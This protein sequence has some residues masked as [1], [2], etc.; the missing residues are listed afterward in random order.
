MVI[1]YFKN[2]L[3]LRNYKFH[4]GWPYYCV[5]GGLSFV[6][7]CSRLFMSVNWMSI[8]VPFKILAMR[9]HYKAFKM[10]HEI[11]GAHRRQ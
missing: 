5:A 2:L 3:H 8:D 7:I 1:N 6:Q 11:N 4:F 10:S 9:V